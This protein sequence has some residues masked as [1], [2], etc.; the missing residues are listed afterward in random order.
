MNVVVHSGLRRARTG[1]LRLVRSVLLHGVPPPPS[2]PATEA[3]LLRHLVLQGQDLARADGAAIVFVD[4]ASAK[5]VDACGALEPLLAQ[6]W[7]ARKCLSARALQAGAPIELGVERGV[8]VSVAA[9]EKL[10]G[11]R[12]LAAV[13]LF[14]T[15]EDGA[16]LLIAYQNGRSR[17]A[18]AGLQAIRTV[19]QEL[20]PRLEQAVLRRRLRETMEERRQLLSEL[21]LA[22]AARRRFLISFGHELRTPLNVL[23]CYVDLLAEGVLGDLEERQRDAVERMAEAG[24]QL[25]E[26]ID[27]LVALNDPDSGRADLPTE[28]LDLRVAA[29]AVIDGLRADAEQSGVTLRVARNKGPP[30][31]VSANTSRVKRI[32]RALCHSAL[33]RAGS[34]EIVICPRPVASGARVD[35]VDARPGA[36]ASVAEGARDIAA[37]LSPGEAKA[38][39][40]MTIAIHLA[41][42]V[43]GRIRV[44]CHQGAYAV[45]SLHLPG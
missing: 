30:P 39:V 17:R 14:G 21:G 16:A 9:V 1:L 8:E 23:I 18:D 41:A 36:P 6:R 45:T 22:L 24:R 25:Q 2:A 38:Q 3:E 11:V 26:L 29:Q 33:S 19:V 40:H 7:D 32:M 12:R 35:F 34:G 13:P 42:L 20:G 28:R 4:A 31:I 15:G 37:P 5:V 44:R 10:N 27:D 43:G